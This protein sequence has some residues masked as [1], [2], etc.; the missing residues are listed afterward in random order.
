MA[1]RNSRNSASAPVLID[2]EQPVRTNVE[3]HPITPIAEPPANTNAI[4]TPLDVEPS[5]ASRWAVLARI[6]DGQGA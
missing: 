1:R 4:D 5:V 3:E 2:T 6:G